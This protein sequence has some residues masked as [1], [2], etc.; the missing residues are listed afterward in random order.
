VAETLHTTPQVKVCGL[1]DLDEALGVAALGVHAVGCVFY[2]RSP[3]HLTRERARAICAALPPDVRRVG[4]FVDE[5]PEAVLRIVRACGLDTVQLHGQ[6]PPEAVERLRGEGLR[7][8]KA[9]FASRAPGPGD[10]DRYHPSAFLMECGAGKLPGGNAETW[11]WAQARPLADRCPLILAGGL[12]PGNVVR[13]IARS[14]PD[15]VDLSSGVEA[16]PGRKDL[17]KVAALMSAV[18][19]CRMERRPRA[20]F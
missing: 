7:V 20:I 1:T 15:A 13:A 3:R 10:A 5:S 12:T 8:I 2:P 6:E 16:A 11:D 4:V 14:Q 9:L 17:G 19:G 18:R